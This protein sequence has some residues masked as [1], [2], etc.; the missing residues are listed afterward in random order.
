M[1]K[2]CPFAIVLKIS[3]ANLPFRCLHLP[4][5]SFS[6]ACL[7]S[8]SA[9]TASEYIA[10][11][12]ISVVTESIDIGLFTNGSTGCRS[13]L[14]NLSLLAIW[15]VAASPFNCVSKSSW[16]SIR[17]WTRRIPVSTRWQRPCLSSGAPWFSRSPSSCYRCSGP[18]KEE[19]HLLFP[20]F[21]N[22][23]QNTL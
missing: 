21:L 16:R 4:I 22:N 15:V 23:V 17:A 18:P 9:W 7:S 3:V 13:G 11:S 14:A 12:W 1:S 10:L 8:S 19:Y 2:K 6:S 20:A 5:C